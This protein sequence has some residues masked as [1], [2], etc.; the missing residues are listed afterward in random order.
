MGGVTKSSAFAKYSID[1]RRY[2]SKGG[3]RKEINEHRNVFATRLM[4]GSLSGSVPFFEQYFVGGAETLRGFKEDR[5][6]GKNMLLASTEYR[7]PLGSSLTGVVF[8]DYGDAWGAPADYLIIPDLDNYTQHESFKGNLGYGVG[9]RV[10]TPIGPLRLDYGFSNEGSRA[11][12]SI[13]QVF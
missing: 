4:A 5:F 9:I 10:Q 1:L 6:W 13:G 8:T 3:A 12:F 2:F 11:H 7:F